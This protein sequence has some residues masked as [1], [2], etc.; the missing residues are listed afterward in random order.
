MPFLLI[1]E[2][3][4]ELSCQQKE[5]CHILPDLLAT[6]VCQVKSCH[7]QAIQVFYK[8]WVVERLNVW[9]FLSN[10]EGR[11]TMEGE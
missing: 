8:R 2:V 9:Y 1:V 7:F 6:Q 3:C 11:L 5:V 10:M 4:T